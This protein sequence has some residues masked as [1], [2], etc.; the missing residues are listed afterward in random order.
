[1]EILRSKKEMQAW[2]EQFQAQGLTIGLVPTMG[3]F[4]QGHLSLMEKGRPLCDRLVVSIFVNPTQF[5]EN[6]DLDAYPIDIERDI[7]LAGKTGVDAVFL[8]TRDDMY[9]P[10]FQTYVEL[11]D[12]PNHLCGKFRPIHFKGVATVVTKL[13]NIVKPQVAV[14]GQKDYQQLQVIRRLT[15]DLDWNIRIEAGEIFREPDGLAMSSRNTYLSEEERSSA[16]SLSKALERARQAVAEGT[17]DVTTLEQDVIRFISSF[18]H[19]TVEYAEFCH[20]Q[21]L[22]NVSTVE[23]KTLLALAVRVGNTRLIDNTVIDPDN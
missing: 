8:P 9:A 13:F 10:G 5:G 22:E 23:G 15:R 6:E 21:T 17:R 11:T 4:H 2:S 14:F 1:M 18:A 16:L 7:E 3:Y 19:T 12:L 20:P